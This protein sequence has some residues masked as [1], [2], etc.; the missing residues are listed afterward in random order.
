MRPAGEVFTKHRDLGGV[1]GEHL[2]GGSWISIQGEVLQAQA[3]RA[4][5]YAALQTSANQ[6]R[7]PHLA[8]WANFTAPPRRQNS[9]GSSGAYLR[10]LWPAVPWCRRS[11]ASGS[12]PMRCRAGSAAKHHSLGADAPPGRYPGARFWSS[13]CGTHGVAQVVLPALLHEPRPAG[14]EP[15]TAWHPA[16]R[17]G[18]LPGHF[19][20]SRTP[21]VRTF[22]CSPLPGMAGLPDNGRI[23]RKRNAPGCI[24]AVGLLICAALGGPDRHRVNYRRRQPIHISICPKASAPG[25]RPLQV[26]T[27]NSA[28]FNRRGF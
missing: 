5:S 22:F 13:P 10:P 14:G 4:N 20:S 6:P 28:T 18:I 24:T 19:I 23:W 25:S 27:A 8:I 17:R 7:A 9:L 11:A 1:Q 12:T 16:R 3:V 21:H 15:E 26:S 2:G